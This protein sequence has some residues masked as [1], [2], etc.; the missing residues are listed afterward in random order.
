MK[1]SGSDLTLGTASSNSDDSGDLVY[2]YGNGNEKMRIWT[3][4]E[5]TAGV[6]PLYRVNKKDGTLLYYG[7][8]AT[9]GEVDG[10]DNAKVEKSGDTMTGGLIM[11]GTGIGFKRG[12]YTSVLVRPIGGQAQDATIYV[13]SKGGTMAINGDCQPLEAPR[14]NSK[15]LNDFPTQNRARVDECNSNCS[16]LPSAYWYYVFTIQGS[17][18]G[19][20]GQLA[21]Q[22][23]GGNAVYYRAKDGGTWSS[24]RSL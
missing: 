8:L 23:T 13:P 9:M 22:M 18:T 7:R 4:N 10:V 16:N 2:T 1:L 19:Y 6:G 21:M 11:D 3:E 15:N 5:Y 20:A 17:D 14:R 12:S 24:W